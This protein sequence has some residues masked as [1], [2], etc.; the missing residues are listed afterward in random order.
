MDAASRAAASGSSVPVE[1]EPSESSTVATSGGSPSFAADGD[2]EG[3]AL[4][5]GEAE[6]A[7][8]AFGSAEGEAPVEPPAAAAVSI[9]SRARSVEVPIASPR[10]VPPSATSESRAA[11]IS[12]RSVVGSHRDLRTRREGHESDLEAG[13]QLVDERRRR[14]LRAGEARWRDIGRHHRAGR[15]HRQDDRR[16]LTRD[17]DHGRR[18][19]R[20]R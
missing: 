8:D 11:W 4:G 20:A 1:L 9:T 3:E 10:A 7:P 16:V 14:L 17:R 6:G 12:A 2:A 5:L 18:V 15:V 19:V 13:W